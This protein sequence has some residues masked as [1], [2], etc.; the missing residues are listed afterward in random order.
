MKIK[1]RAPSLVFYF[2]PYDWSFRTKI[3]VGS[4]TDG[5][6]Q[7]LGRIKTSPIVLLIKKAPIPR[8]PL[9]YLVKNSGPLAVYVF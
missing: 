1:G 5:F 4:A 8:I 6:P 9:F 7:I 2:Q 3:T